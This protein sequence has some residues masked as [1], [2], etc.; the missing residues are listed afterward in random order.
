MHLGIVLMSVGII[1]IEG[2]QQETQATLSIGDAVEL[3]GYSFSFEQLEHR[4]ETAGWLVTEAR[5]DISRDGESLGA[6]YPVREIYP[7]MG[8]AV[9]LP[10]LQ[11]NLAV[12]LYA[13]L[14]DWQP[15]SSDQATFRIFYN[16]LVTWL[17]VGAG[18]L[19][20]GVVVALLPRS[21]RR[22]AVRAAQF[23]P[24]AG[25]KLP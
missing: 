25:Q 21:S 16:P 11:S 22:K 13:I 5:L 19:T 8:M 4:E 3:G 24:L 7:N 12:D 9:T 23:E 2:L 15:I 6:L 1:G 17:W 20:A 18:L 14:V 10:G